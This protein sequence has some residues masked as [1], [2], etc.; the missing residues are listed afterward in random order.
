MGDLLAL[1]VVAR[2]ISVVGTVLRVFQHYHDEI[3]THVDQ[4]AACGVQG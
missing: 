2:I 4:Q 3:G 1:H